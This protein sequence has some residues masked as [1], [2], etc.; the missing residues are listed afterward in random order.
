M[1]LAGNAFNGGV[2]I[3]VLTA[4]LSTYPW[5][6]SR[7]SAQH[8][9]PSGAEQLAGIDGGA[10]QPA[11]IRGGAEQPAAID[12]V[13]MTPQETATSGDEQG[14][15]FGDPSNARRQARA[16]AVATAENEWY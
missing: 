8:S 9:L 4:A 12:G 10:E 3:G 15:S 2:L 7:S 6:A 11:G 1:D 14:D 5:S 13:P 16:S